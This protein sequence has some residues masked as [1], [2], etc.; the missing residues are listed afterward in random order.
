MWQRAESTKRRTD[1][2]EEEAELA[3]VT[4]EE[5]EVEPAKVQQRERCRRE[6]VVEGDK[7]PANKR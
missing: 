7:V 4:R 3:E 5:E 2:E 6:W 1:R